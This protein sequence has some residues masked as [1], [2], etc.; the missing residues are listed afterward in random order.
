M[1]QKKKELNLEKQPFS[2]ENGGW[3]ASYAL[4]ESVLCAF[5]LFFLSIFF[6]IKMYR[7][8]NLCRI[9]RPRKLDF[10]RH[11]NAFLKARKIVKSTFVYCFGSACYDVKVS[12]VARMVGCTKSSFM[13]FKVGRLENRLRTLSFFRFAALLHYA[14]STAVARREP[15]MD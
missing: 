2:E 12:V 5:L 4:F 7:N 3:E 10:A 8:D 15:C 11:W 1:W 13:H 9:A 14:R 6:H